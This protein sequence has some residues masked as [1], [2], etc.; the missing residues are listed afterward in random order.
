[1]LYPLSYVRVSVYDT[2][3]AESI[4]AQA[5]AAGLFGCDR[6][7]AAFVPDHAHAA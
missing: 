4:W 2:F 1:M 7:G 5:S 3:R 6:K